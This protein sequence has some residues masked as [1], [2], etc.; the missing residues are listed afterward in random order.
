[1]SKVNFQIWA[2][3]T[4][5]PT[6]CLRLDRD[7]TLM[8]LELMRR[9][10]TAESPCCPLLVHACGHQGKKWIFLYTWHHQYDQEGAL[11]PP[12]PIWF[13]DH[14]KDPIPKEIMCV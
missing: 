1:M 3:V 7:Q 10:W 6:L 11:G 4:V 13:C 2:D 8:R 9:G 14:D 5:N 12:A